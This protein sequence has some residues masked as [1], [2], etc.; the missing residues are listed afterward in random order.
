MVRA[1]GNLAPYQQALQTLSQTS[2]LDYPMQVQFETLTLCPGACH[3]CPYTQ[4]SHKGHKMDDALIDKILSD[5]SEIPRQL[6]FYLLPY[7]VNE[8]FLDKRLPALLQDINRRLPNARLI[9]TSTGVPLTEAW[10]DQ[11]AQI[12]NIDTL[13]LSLNDHRPEHYTRTMQLPW[14]R[15]WERLQLLHRYKE[16]G[17]FPFKV[18][19]WRVGD[20]S[21]ADAEFV[22][23][24]RQHFPLFEAQCNA[25]GEWLGLVPGLEAT[26]RIPDVGCLRWYEISITSTGKVAFCCMDA[27]AD[28]PIGDVRTQHVL[29][30]YNQPSYRRLRQQAPSRLQVSPCDKCSMM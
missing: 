27:Q 11:L 14:E 17:R 20:N 29:D 3:F 2:Y 5:L 8:P 18:S 7:K 19:L 9:L 13:S 26:H 12:A 15:T 24:C 10:L 6:P 25:R 30:I 16:S 4:L 28:W 22:A 1:Q 23:W 21:P